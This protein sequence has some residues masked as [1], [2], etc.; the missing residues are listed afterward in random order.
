[1]SKDQ[2]NKLP[3][4]ILLFGIAVAC[5]GLV[6]IYDAS[7]VDAFKTFGD[8]FH[9]V[10][11]QSSWLILGIIVALITSKIPLEL[12]KKLAPFFLGCS[13][14][15]MVLVLIP[16]IGSKLLGARRWIIFG[17]IVIQPSELLKISLIIYQIGRA[18]V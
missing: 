2:K 10:K 18:H 11:Q 15:L 7:V 16:G 12:I 5:L 9:Y 3:L 8:K 13:L 17:P 1:M 14:I 4:L 6:A